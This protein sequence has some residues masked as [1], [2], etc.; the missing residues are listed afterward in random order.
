MTVNRSLTQIIERLDRIERALQRSASSQITSPCCQPLTNPT[1]GDP[2]PVLPP[3]PAE[4]QPETDLTCARMYA[5]L[6]SKV[7]LWNS[8]IS[9]P[10]PAW[11]YA[12]AAGLQAVILGGLGLWAAN[13]MSQALLAQLFDLIQDVRERAGID[14]INY[15]DAAR[16]ALDHQDV[17]AVPT[18]IWDKLNVFDRAIFRV[19]WML[20]GGLQGYENVDPDPD[21]PLGCCLPDVFLLNP[22]VRTFTCGSDSYDLQVIG[23]SDPPGVARSVIVNR[24]GIPHVV[25]SSIAGFWVRGV[26]RPGAFSLWYYYSNTVTNSGCPYI[27]TQD[28]DMPNEHWFLV[29]IT[30][31]PYIVWRNRTSYEGTY[32]EVSRSEPSGWNG[33]DTI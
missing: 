18:A 14:D 22:V 31:S 33:I 5:L 23:E 12:G 8:I 27:Q 19:Y 20:T 6:K 29:T 21:T 16:E 25:R 28:G 24:A 10:L 15:C 32:I 1:T 4:T 26:Q 3:P 11:L 30:G 9:D 7:A 2:L 17:L 13:F